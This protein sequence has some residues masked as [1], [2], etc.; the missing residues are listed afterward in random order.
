MRSD[1]PV[2]L[3]LSSGVDSA[4]LL[5]MMRKHAGAPVHTFT[6][7][8]EGGEASN[9]TADARRTANEYGAVHSEMIL[10]PSDY[11]R[12]YERY[13]WDIEEPWATSR[14]RRSTS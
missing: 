1:V 3:F 13:L 9:E 4:A 7:G 14:R 10:G 8:F 11:E 5:A 2:G 6:I 12:Y